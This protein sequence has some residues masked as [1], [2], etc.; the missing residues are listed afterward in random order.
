MNAAIIPQYADLLDGQLFNFKE[1]DPTL[2]YGAD[3]IGFHK[4]KQKF[5]SEGDCLSTIDQVALSEIDVCIFIDLNYY[6]LDKFLDLDDPPLLVYIMREPPSVRNYNSESAITK[7]APLFDGIFTWN[8]LL[9]TSGPKFTKY[10]IPQYLEMAKDDCPAFTDQKLLVNITS[11]KYSHHP[12]ELYSAREEV[13]RYYDENHP[14]QFTLYGQYWNQRSR[15]EDVYHHQKLTSYNYRTY[16]GLIEDKTTAYR[17][18]KFTLCFENMTGINGYVT[19]KLFDCFRAGTVP[20]Y[21]G[22]N[23]ISEIVPSDAFIDYR[24]YSSPTA[25]HDYLQSIDRAEYNEYLSKA[26]EFI[27]DDAAHVSPERYAETIH[28]KISSMKR[29]PSKSPS[30][31][32]LEEISN[33]AALEKLVDYSDDM[34]TKDRI[35]TLW[36]VIRSNPNLILL[37]PSSVL[38]TFKRT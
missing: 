4:L 17:H 11:R 16:K 8:D 27:L 12:E 29:R 34:S 6:Y 22:A 19:E 25:L 38:S 18:H 37:N 9:S 13:I 3:R 32:I 30:S 15:L 31:M 33:H 2:P 36:K 26:Q 1:Y 20:I 23:N 21:W 5:N 14:D 28:A 24:N 35:S 10:R 7:Y